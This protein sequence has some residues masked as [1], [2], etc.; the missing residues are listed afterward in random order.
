[1]KRKTGQLEGRRGSGNVVAVSRRTGIRKEGVIRRLKIG[2]GWG[3]IKN[4]WVVGRK[5]Q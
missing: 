4:E 3:R 1:V 2:E 5:G